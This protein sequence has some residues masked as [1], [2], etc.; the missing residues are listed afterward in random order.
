M[1]IEWISIND[2]LPKKSKAKVLVR[3]THI[4]AYSHKDKLIEYKYDIL[5]WEYDKILIESKRDG[6]LETNTY[7]IRWKFSPCDDYNYITDWTYLD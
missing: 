6:D 3:K 4:Y 1:M 2:E 7:H 5:D